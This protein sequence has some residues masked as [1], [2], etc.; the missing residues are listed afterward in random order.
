MYGSDDGLHWEAGNGA[1][2]RGVHTLIAR[3]GT[4]ASRTYALLLRAM[5]AGGYPNRARRWEPVEFEERAVLRR[6]SPA[7]RFI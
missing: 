6:R 4:A 7:T 1:F 2:R 5:D 3:P